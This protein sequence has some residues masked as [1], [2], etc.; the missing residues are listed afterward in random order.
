LDEIDDAL[1]ALR[2]S[3]QLDSILDS[4]FPG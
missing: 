4:W 3:G 1:I 2:D